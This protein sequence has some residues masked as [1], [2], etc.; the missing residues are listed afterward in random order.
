MLHSF[1]ISDEEWNNAN[2][3]FS[4]NPE[5]VKLS[6]KLNPQVRHSF[7]KADNMVYAIANTSSEGKDIA[8]IGIGGF[9]VNK[10]GIRGSDKKKVKVK[11]E[12]RDSRDENNS[13][14]T[15]HQLLNIFY[16]QALEAC[17]GKTFNKTS[18]HSKIV[19][20]K[21][22]TI[23][24]L[25]EGKDA[26]EFVNNHFS[27]LPYYQFLI[28]LIECC[29]ALQSL[30]DKGIIHADT[31]PD[32]III[33]REENKIEVVIIDYDFS[34]KL[35][36]DQKYILGEKAIG[37]ESF[38][39]P[40][41]L[42]NTIKYSFASD[43]YALGT[44]FKLFLKHFIYR[45]PEVTMNHLSEFNIKKLKDLF[46][47]MRDETPDER[48]LL[49]NVMF[50]IAGL[51][52]EQFKTLNQ[53]EGIQVSGVIDKVNKYQSSHINI[54]STQLSILPSF[55]ALKNPTFTKGSKEKGRDNK[56]NC[57]N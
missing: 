33:N 39:A 42:D 48:P 23:M 8:I 29:L 2:T 18:C 6:R 1:L 31:K 46:Y 11:I 51:L 49:S 22:Y 4:E 55:N 20:K 30:H 43:V 21:L 28:L 25:F 7:I 38:T 32:N 15:I 19:E 26:C 45:Q 16:G 3:Y 40:E 17:P 53:N 50:E 27:T 41:I 36:P 14:F 10:L 56:F 57:K 35:L 24:E 34:K 37:T 5:K 54:I 44:T 13:A 52:I 12:G 9:S 47:R